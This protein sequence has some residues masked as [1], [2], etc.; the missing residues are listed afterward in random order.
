M[1]N[2]SQVVVRSV[3]PSEESRFQEFMQ[4]Y[5][6]LGTLPKTGNT[7][8]YIAICNNEWPG[9]FSFSAAALK[10]GVRDRWIGWGHLL[11]YD[12]LHLVANNSR[13]IGRIY[14]A[15]NWQ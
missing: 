5:H 2:L 12:R 1:L 4:Q 3:D 9:F 6:Y 11:Q 8:W 15:T 7:I 13:F 10:C 14:H